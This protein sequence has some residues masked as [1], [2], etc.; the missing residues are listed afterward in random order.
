MARGAL[1]LEGRFLNPCGTGL[2]AIGL[3][4]VSGIDVGNERVVTDSIRFTDTLYGM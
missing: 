2:S 1:N 4:A 3:L